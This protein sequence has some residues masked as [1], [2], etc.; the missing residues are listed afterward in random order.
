MA[1]T[2]GIDLTDEYIA[3]FETGKEQASIWP[4]VICREKKGTEWY[5]GEEAYRE[6]L[7]GRAVMTEKLLRLLRKDGTSTI[8][9][10]VYP[11]VELLSM[12]IRMVLLHQLENG[13]IASI[14]R[15]CLCL[16]EPDRELL[17]RVAES[18]VMAGIDRE[19]ILMTSH[20]EA[21]L[22][23]V[24]S[25]EKEIYSNMACLFDLSSETLSYYEFMVVRGMSRKCAIAEGEDIEEAFH[26]DILRKDSGRTLGDRIITDVAKRHMDGKIFSGVFLTGSGFE[27]TDWAP[28]FL[29]YVCNRRRVMYEKGLFAMGAG[30]M[31][32][33]PAGGTEEYLIFCN[34]RVSSEVTT[35]VTVGERKSE[36]ILVPAG[37]RWYGLQVHVEVMPREQDY[38][39]LTV[40]PF[41]K[42]RETRTGR[43]E[44]SEFPKRPDRTTR[45]AMDL[46]FRDSSTL[47]CKLSDMGFGEIFPASG[48][49]IEKEF[50]T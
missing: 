3:V 21:F 5:I 8:N 46:T 30:I 47:C 31:A 25:R 15:V 34:M 1:L 18:A 32:G 22:S 19:K 13:E 4:A 17:D 11:A 35:E 24:L 10:K 45:T 12:L 33:E 38:L 40:R 9:R 20:E 29:G 44:L 26:T 28:S 43:V 37:K 2:F 7:S 48:V 41:D 39:E 23:Y 6:A 14:D 27:R 50:D 36:L 42:S 49:T 16:H